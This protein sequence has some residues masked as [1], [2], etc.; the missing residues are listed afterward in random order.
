MAEDNDLFKPN[1]YLKTHKEVNVAAKDIPKGKVILDDDLLLEYRDGPNNYD[2]HRIVPFEATRNIKKGE[3]ITDDMLGAEWREVW[4]AKRLIKKDEVLN[5]QLFDCKMVKKYNPEVTGLD[6]DPWIWK[7]TFAEKDI[8]KGAPV[9]GEDVR[10]VQPKPEPQKQEY[11][12]VV[13]PVASIKAGEVLKPEQFMLAKVDKLSTVKTDVTKIESLTTG[14]PRCFT[15][16]VE[17]FEPVSL[18]ETK[19]IK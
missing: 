2:R 17:A 19:L 16:D 8:S 18:N 1:V 12:Q 14:T 3:D 9:L 11:Q 4:F 6:T 13:I 5:P 7:C 15:H 10:Y